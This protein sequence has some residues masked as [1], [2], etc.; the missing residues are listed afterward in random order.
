MKRQGGS[1]QAPNLFGTHALLAQSLGSL[2][3][4]L[5][6]AASLTD[7]TRWR[8]IHPM[9][10]IPFRSSGLVAPKGNAGFTTHVRFGSF[11]VPGSPS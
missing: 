8:T 11:D 10:E 3:V 9:P 6:L 7:G 4:E 1:A 2:F 5:R